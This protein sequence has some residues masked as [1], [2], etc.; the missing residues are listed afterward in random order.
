MKFFTAVLL[1]ITS[2]AYAEHAGRGLMRHSHPG[3]VDT[4]E[5]LA[6]IVVLPT[7]PVQVKEVAPPRALEQSSVAVTTAPDT[8]DPK[9]LPPE[10][11]TAPEVASVKR[12]PSNRIQDAFEGFIAE[13]LD[14]NTEPEHPKPAIA[15]KLQTPAI[16]L[17]RPETIKSPQPTTATQEP[18]AE[19][20]QMMRDFHLSSPPT[21]L[22]A[23]NSVRAA[24]TNY[25]GVAV[26]APS[27][28]YSQQPYCKECQKH[29]SY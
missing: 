20:L 13:I 11:R 29:R 10:F 25:R 5:Q 7:T 9:Y 12:K 3:I 17:I 6:E 19:Q 14:D 8:S 28:Y 1:L 4:Q 26:P 15:I 2:T 21:I 22:N 23:D 27:V 24:G 16:K 18:T